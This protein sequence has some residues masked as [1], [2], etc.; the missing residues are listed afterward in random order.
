MWGPTEHPSLKRHGA[1]RP[2]SPLIIPYE[3]FMR[4]CFNH[5]NL[6]TATAAERSQRE[7]Q[8]RG[9]E[10]RRGEEEEKRR[11]EER[12]GVKS[13]G[14]EWRVEERKEERKWQ[15]HSAL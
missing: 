9:E 4:V 13:R 1:A 5:S 12:K 3:Y 14:E 11:G 7:E 8:E 2:R 15:A 6:A 10:K